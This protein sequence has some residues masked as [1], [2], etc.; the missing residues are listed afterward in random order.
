MYDAAIRPSGGKDQM[1]SFLDWNVLV[2]TVTFADDVGDDDDNAAG[3]NAT[4]QPWEYYEAAVTTEEPT[5]RVELAKSAQ[6][7]CSQNSATYRRCTQIWRTK[8]DKKTGEEKR[9]LVNPKIAKGEV[10]IGHYE[11]KTGGYGRWMHLEV[12]LCLLVCI[13]SL[14][15]LRIPILCRV[16]CVVISYE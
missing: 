4:V 12:S 14:L 2:Q 10:R 11:D 13:G 16:I 5:Y 7:T 6:S 9:T 1:T 15:L 8:V 3:T